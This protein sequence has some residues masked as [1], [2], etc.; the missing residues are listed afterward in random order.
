MGTVYQIAAEIA[1]E[2]LPNPEDVDPGD[3]AFVAAR[4][5]VNFWRT[6]EL[7]TCSVLDRFAKADD[8]SNYEPHRDYYPWAMLVQGVEAI[9]RR[10]RSSL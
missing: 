9:I 6:S 2:L 8:A 5:L 1:A 7:W 4:D 3:L 10:Y